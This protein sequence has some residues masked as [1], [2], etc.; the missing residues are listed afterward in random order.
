MASRRFILGILFPPQKFPRKIWESRKHQ[1][2]NG[3]ALSTDVQNW[4]DYDASQ[5]PTS[6]AKCE[7]MDMSHYHESCISRFL[8]LRGPVVGERAACAEVSI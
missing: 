4:H 3:V 2:Q 7:G 1:H 8:L 6:T 5:L